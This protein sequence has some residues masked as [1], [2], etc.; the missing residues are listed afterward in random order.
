M[1]AQSLS[2]WLVIAF[3]ACVASLAVSLWTMST[4]RLSAQN[5]SERLGEVERLAKQVNQLREHPT[6]ERR[7]SATRQDISISIESAAAEVGVSSSQLLRIEP[8]PR[9]REERG[10][11]YVLTP[12]R[13]EIENATLDSLLRMASRLISEDPTLNLGQA[14]FSYDAVQSEGGVELWDGEL[15]LTR[16]L[17]LPK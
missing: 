13:V 9:V 17:Y 14:R 8:L 12:T 3:G 7:E 15:T 4:A 11:D 5:A 6:L 10:G 2:S 1:A 16:R